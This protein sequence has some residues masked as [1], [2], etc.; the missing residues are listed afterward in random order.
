MVAVFKKDNGK[1]WTRDC[2]NQQPLLMHLLR[3]QLSQPLHCQVGTYGMGVQGGGG[4]EVFLMVNQP[5]T[6]HPT[7][8]RDKL[9]GL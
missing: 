8:E 3:N 7:K 2:P 9:V 1:S 4:G 5:V 6:P